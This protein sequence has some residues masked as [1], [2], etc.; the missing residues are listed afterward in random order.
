MLLSEYLQPTDLCDYNKKPKI[1]DLA[2]S[3][4][5]NLTDMR[6]KSNRIF[7][8]V[9]E[10]YYRYDDWDVKAS[11]TLREKAGMC[12]GK[13]NLFITML[14]SIGIPARYRVF[15]VEAELALFAWI[16]QQDE[17]IARQMGEPY[18]EQDHVIAEVYINGWEAFDTSHDTPFEKGLRKLGIPVDLK[19]ILLPNTPRPIILASFDDWARDR[20]RRRRFTGTRHTVFSLANEQ[21]EKIRLMASGE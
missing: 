20:Q 10:L 11:D 16:T 4:A 18:Q 5:A 7:N 19:P 8:F 17:R 3:L 12:S 14:R 1:K 13:T 9:K 21:L 6:Q 2:L 15:K